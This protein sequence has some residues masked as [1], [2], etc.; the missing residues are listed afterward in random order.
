[1]CLGLITKGEDV[2]FKHQ[3]QELNE[4]LVARVFGSW[5]Y[6]S[7]SVCYSF[8]GIWEWYILEE[9]DHII[10]DYAAARW[11]LFDTLNKLEEV[12]S[13]LDV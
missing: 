6:L 12:C 13:V 2:L 1:M 5:T 8:S 9:G 10:S 4:R 11:N 3:I 7:E